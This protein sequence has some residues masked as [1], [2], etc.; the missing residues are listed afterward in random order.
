MSV[1]VPGPSGRPDDVIV[2]NVSGGAFGVAALEVSEVIEL[3]AGYSVEEHS[4]TPWVP[5]L[6]ISLTTDLPLLTPGESYHLSH[7]EPSNSQTNAAPATNSVS[8]PPTRNQPPKPEPSLL[9][10]ETTPSSLDQKKALKP[11]RL[12]LQSSLSSVT[13]SSTSLVNVTARAK[14]VRS[15]VRFDVDEKQDKDEYVPL[16][17]IM[18]I[19]RGREERAKF[20]Q[21]EKDRR[22]LEEGRQKHEAEK[23][24]WEQE[25]RA[26]EAERKAIEDEKKKR[27]YQQEVIA[28]RRRRESQAFQV[29]SPSADSPEI[30]PQTSR[31]QTS[32][33][34][35]A[36]DSLRRQSLDGSPLEVSHPPS[37]DGSFGSL[38]GISKPPSRNSSTTSS[39]NED[40][41]KTTTRPI[42]ML[43]GIA[44][45]F[46]MMMQP[47]GYPW[48]MPVMTQMSMPMQM[49]PQ[50]PYY[51]PMDNMPLL[52]PTAPFM[53]QH[54][55]DRRNS[56]RPSSPNKSST[57]LKESASQSV[58]RLPLNKG[59]SH[60]KRPTGH[61]RSSSGG[62]SNQ[63]G[64]GQQSNQGSISSRRSSG[65]VNDP[66]Q[67]RNSTRL[68]PSMPQSHSQRP[69]S[70]VFPSQVPQT[71]QS[72]VS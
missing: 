27:L 18:R 67:W 5:P 70:W 44:P 69:G 9:R 68:R 72:T 60:P 29:G 48:G 50:L 45:Q 52:P 65:V 41:A 14:R 25:K 71:R 59:T 28:A 58:D 38:R 17:Q 37:R 51:Y 39:S 3:L 8:T 7:D 10:S 6:S 11:E 56:S 30:D 2:H 35:P 62:S 13:P 15:S 31:R 23:R 40:P 47:L 33:S 46:P 1:Y 34:R 19:K 61:H 66:S 21:L 26:W 54:T 42:S 20:L 63:L 57:S 49:V 55:G 22:D 4:E 43:P 12:P 36:Y 64:P 53:M 24:K 16:V 32:Y